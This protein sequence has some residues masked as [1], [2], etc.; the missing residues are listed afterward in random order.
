MRNLSGMPLLAVLRLL[1]NEVLEQDRRRFA[2]I[3]ALYL[4]PP[5]TI[6]PPGLP[7][8]G[9]AMHQAR[10]DLRAIAIRCGD[11]KPESVAAEVLRRMPEDPE[12]AV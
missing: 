6:C 3:F 8:H 5:E 7:K 1:A 12:I 4:A 10:K 9:E 2:Q 11:A